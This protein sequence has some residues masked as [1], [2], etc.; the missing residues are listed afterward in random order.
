MIKTAPVSEI[1]DEI[2]QGKMVIVVDDE[3]R[4]NECDL[5]MAA[6]KV[7][8]EAIN[9][10]SKYG[11]GLI[12]LAL[13]RQRCQQLD[14]PLMVTTT[15]VR[16]ATNF[17]I[18]IDARHKITTGI[19]A[20]D[21][22][23]TIQQ[24]I[25]P[26]ASPHDM[27]QPGHIFPLME[28][29]GGVLTRAG[30]TEA[31]C[32]LARLAGCEPAAVIVEIL[33]EDGS[34]ARREN[35]GAFAQQHGLKLVTVAD[36][37]RHRIASEQ[38]IYCEKELPIQTR[39]GDMNLYLFNDTV[40]HSKHFAL[41]LGKPDAQQPFPVRVHVENSLVDLLGILSGDQAENKTWSP[42]D[43]LKYIFDEGAGVFVLLRLPEHLSKQIANLNQ[44]KPGIQ[45][46]D[47]WQVGVGGQILQY[48]QV[49]KMRLMS[50]H[51]AFIG[52]HGFGLSVEDYIEKNEG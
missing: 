21:R 32:D 10:M 26:D 5:V 27:V 42:Q 40:N 41:M 11:R 13:S 22:A 8:P 50:S 45:D 16:L 36:L 37:I 35:I 28:Q 14:L 49:K 19:S 34:M 15:D 29:P 39:Y 46:Y 12:C 47:R 43:A 51:K 23:E 24:A 31:G 20:Q 44:D 7:T 17:T 1:V 4:E 38:T 30:H 52:L 9:F 18:S 2:R 3:E 48:L 33:N 6:E 25:A